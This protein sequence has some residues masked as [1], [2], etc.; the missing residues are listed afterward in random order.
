M[1]F[2]E[3]LETFISS[4]KQE[5]HCMASW[6]HGS[7]PSYRDQFIF[8]QMYE[9][10]SNVL[11]HREH[12][13]MASYKPNLSITIAWGIQVGDKD[14]NVDRDWATNNPD[15]DGGKSN[16][17]DFFYNNALVFRT[18]YCT[19]DGGRCEI[20]F[21]TYD[22]SG[23]I[24]VP[25]QYHDLIKKFS[26]IVNGANIFDDYFKRTGISIREVEW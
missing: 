9:G 16:Y 23:D 13:N 21:P 18:S 22:E 15:K 6:G 4:H 11:E 14:D 10:E 25:K 3:L 5:W 19:V 12:S 2:D 24:Y 7:G 20:P 8:S 26:E 17:L 1:T